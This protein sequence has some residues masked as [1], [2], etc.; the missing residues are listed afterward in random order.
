[1]RE[2]NLIVFGGRSVEHDISII[3]A[4]QMK[5]FLQDSEL[6]YIDKSG[7][8]WIAENLDDIKVYL[9][10]RKQAKNKRRVTILGGENVLMVQKHFKYVPLYKIKSVLNCCHG[11]IG[12]DG[13]LQGLLRCSN[14]PQ[15]SPS[16]CASAICMDKAF[17]KDILKANKILTPEGETIK[18]DDYTEKKNETLNRLSKISF[19]IITKPANLGSSIGISLCK[20][21]SELES[22]IELAFEFDKKVVCEKFVENLREFN[23]AC[24][25]VRQNLFVS[26]VIEVENKSDIFSFA[27]KYVS[28]DTKNSSPSDSLSKK[29]K[30]LTE[31]V[32]SLFD[33]DGIVRI[34]FLYDN[35]SKRLYVNELNTIPGSL[36]C[37][38]FK[39]MDFKEILSCVIRQSKE[40]LLDENR[41]VKNFESDALLTY[42]NTAK[43]FKK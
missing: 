8:W 25:K 29:I 42:I 34:D 21:I 5:K 4:M 9:N 6:V 12:E 19:P 41:L 40:N 38:M 7:L 27:D 23:C 33:C 39:G 10:F 22:A 18:R 15:S 1:M 24:F 17:V 26:D 11:N 2:K 37:H 13:S 16:V 3:T 20:D 35:K 32:Y 28:Q 31:K 14:I 30:S 36:S 43:T